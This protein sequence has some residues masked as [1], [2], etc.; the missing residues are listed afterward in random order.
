[1][2][3]VPGAEQTQVTGINDRGQ[4]VGFYVDADES[5]A[6]SAL[7]A[8]QPADSMPT[9]EGLMSWPVIHPEHRW[10]RTSL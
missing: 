6:A 4:M 3:D 10:Q 5:P 2:I 1:M 9:L 7:A 8:E